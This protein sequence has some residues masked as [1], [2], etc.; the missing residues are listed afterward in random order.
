MDF[1]SPPRARHQE[2]LLPMIN[3]VFLLLIFFLITATL[4]PPEPIAVVLPEAQTA[5]PGDAPAALVLFMGEDG[6]LGF[7]EALGREA[8]L[9]ALAQ[10]RSAF[11]VQADCALVAPELI[12]RADAK[13]GAA[14]VAAL[15]PAVRAL[16]FAQ[17]SLRTARP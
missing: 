14:E 10:A 3:V 6:Q 1:S 15:L 16:G 17:M 5:E 11:C 7:G 8:A 4:A 9:A 13:V 12:L 2:N